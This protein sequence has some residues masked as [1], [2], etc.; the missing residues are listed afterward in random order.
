M[1][2]TR[3]FNVLSAT[4]AATDDGKK[5]PLAAAGLCERLNVVLCPPAS[6]HYYPRKSNVWNVDPIN[7]AAYRTF[8]STGICLP[9]TKGRVCYRTGRTSNAFA[10]DRELYELGSG[11][12]VANRDLEIRGAGSLFRTEQSGMAARMSFDLHMRISG[13]THATTPRPRSSIGI[14]KQRNSA[15]TRR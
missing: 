14:K 1:P 4:H 10:S 11:F 12:D 5:R 13:E 9:L 2:K 3:I 7:C 15:K 8:R 6:R